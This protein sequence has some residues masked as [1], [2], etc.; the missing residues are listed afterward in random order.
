MHFVTV[1]KSIFLWIVL[2]T[3]DMLL[4]INAVS[5][6]SSV[7]YDS[8]GK[9]DPFT[10]LVTTSTHEVSGLYGIESVDDL[11]VEGVIYDPKNGSIAVING[12]VIKEGEEIGGLKVLRIQPEGVYVSLNGSEAYKPLYQEEVSRKNNEE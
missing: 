7:V 10:P 8:H 6:E 3:F 2:L 12:S 11:T 4:P 5:V 9:R 1:K